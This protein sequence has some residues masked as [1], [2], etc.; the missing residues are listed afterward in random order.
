MGFNTAA[1]F[2]NDGIRRD[3]E[4][5]QA[6]DKSTVDAV[7][8]NGDVGEALSSEDADDVQIVAIGGNSI[9]RLGTIYS[10]WRLNTGKKED[11]IQ[12]LRMLANR[13]GFDLRKQPKKRGW[14]AT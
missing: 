9:S 3:T 7:L 1:I 8:K 2:L 4:F 13:Y 10:G 11:N 12:L 14:Y 6:L 5:Y